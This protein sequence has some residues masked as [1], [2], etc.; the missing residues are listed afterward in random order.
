M[1]RSTNV[2]IYECVLTHNSIMYVQPVRWTY[3][4]SDNWTDKWVGWVGVWGVGVWVCGCVF[5]CLGVWVFGCLGVWVFGC[6]GGCLG[7]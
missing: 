1:R 2:S 6:L 3:G 5:G 7:V 4:R